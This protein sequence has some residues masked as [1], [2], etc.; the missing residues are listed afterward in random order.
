MSN[1][2]DGLSKLDD[3]I[4]RENIAMLEATTMWS[5]IKLMI[6]NL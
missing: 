2:F 4:I 3:Y 6:I 5:V 1:I